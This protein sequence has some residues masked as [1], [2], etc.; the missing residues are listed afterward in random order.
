MLRVRCSGLD[1]QGSRLE[2]RGNRGKGYRP[3]RKFLSVVAG[4]A[5]V[6]RPDIGS[7][8]RAFR[9]WMRSVRHSGRHVALALHDDFVERA[10][11]LWPRRP[12]YPGR[13][14]RSSN[15]PDGCIP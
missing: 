7:G 6:S 14:V 12:A 2:V 9:M 8:E 15:G 11:R 1:S 10:D 5:V 3:G 4:R 13:R